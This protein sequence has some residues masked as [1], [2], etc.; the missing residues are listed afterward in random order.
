MHMSIWKTVYDSEAFI[1]IRVKYINSYYL[2]NKS[3]QPDILLGKVQIILIKTEN[4]PGLVRRVGGK[5]LGVIEERKRW[6]TFV[7]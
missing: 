6:S 5:Y 3:N 1:N 2:I 4:F 7:G